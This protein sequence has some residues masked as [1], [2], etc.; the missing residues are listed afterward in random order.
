MP[1]SSTAA[2]RSKK[3]VPVPTPAALQ[4][5]ANLAKFAKKEA[6]VRYGFISRERADLPAPPLMRLL[7]GER[8]GSGGSVR[9]GLLLSMLWFVHDD[10]TI[11]FPARAWA[12][13]L[14]LEGPEVQG[15]RRIKTALRWL[16]NNGF[17]QL[18]TGPGRD[19]VVHLL[20]D[21]G[22]GRRYELPGATYRRL[23]G[24][25]AAA[26]PHRYIRLPRELWTHGW[27]SV[28]SGPAITMLLILWLESGR[29]VVSERPPWV[30]LSPKMAE[31]RYALSEETRL[32]GAR[33]LTNLG[34]INTARRA[35]SPESFEFRRGRNV[36][37]ID[38]EALMT[39]P[40]G[41]SLSP[42]MNPPP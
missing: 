23:K 38:R 34:L 6:P 9:I 1:S 36:H 35:V 10:P 28:M 2:N 29:E 19:A 39:G 5:A 33:E 41:T 27:L 13:L 17:I 40:P 26:A 32:K 20:E 3:P 11:V 42:F 24:N 31:E 7:R 30:W 8:G 14:G 15:A 18:E 21:T 4:A 37:Q 16:D 12:S 25:A 22:S